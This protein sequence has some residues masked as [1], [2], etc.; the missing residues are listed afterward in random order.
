[1]NAR[2]SIRFMKWVG[3]KMKAG[4][5]LTEEEALMFEEAPRIGNTLPVS[6]LNRKNL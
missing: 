4:D 1:M 6:H 3:E 2:N 5:N